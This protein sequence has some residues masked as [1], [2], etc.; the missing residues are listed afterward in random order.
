MSLVFQVMDGHLEQ[1]I[2][3]IIE[4]GEAQAAQEII[5]SLHDSCS[6]VSLHQS[7][8]ESYQAGLQHGVSETFLTSTTTTNQPILSSTSRGL[9]TGSSASAHVVRAFTN[10]GSSQSMQFTLDLLVLLAT[11]GQSEISYS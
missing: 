11:L 1:D 6:A 2:T 7:L 4:R 9:V 10:I 5:P 3:D 8:E